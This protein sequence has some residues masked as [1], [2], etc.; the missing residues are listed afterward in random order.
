MTYTK[1]S[2]L[3]PNDELHYIEDDKGSSTEE[4][5]KQHTK[6]LNRKPEFIL[7]EYTI[8]NFDDTRHTL[9]HNNIKHSVYTDQWDLDYIMI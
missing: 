1:L 8:D 4:T 5:R 7:Y 3:L 6:I 9:R 2:K